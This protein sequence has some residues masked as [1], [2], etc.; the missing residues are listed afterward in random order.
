MKTNHLLFLAILWGLL[1]LLAPSASAQ[2]ADPNVSINVSAEVISSIEMITVQSMQLS[3]VE[4]VNDVITVD[5]KKSTYTGKIIAIGNPNAEIQI[6][7]LKQRELTQQRGANNLLFNYVIA[8]NNEDDQSS[9]EILES[10]N[11]GLRMNKNGRFYLWVG[12]SVDISTANPGS[13]QGEFTL[14]VDY[15]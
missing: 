5:P 7:F 1:N 2:N 9:A 14:E 15:I 8:G 12:G 4:P 13:Y 10:D 6:S 11:R 3:Q